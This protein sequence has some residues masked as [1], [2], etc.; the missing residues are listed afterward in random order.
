MLEHIAGP[1]I[2]E[3]EPRR[4]CPG[5]IAHRHQHCT[6]CKGQLVAGRWACFF[7]EGEVVLQIGHAAPIFT[8]GAMLRPEAVACG[9]VPRPRRSS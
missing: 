9:P 2:D 5:Y 4:S 6:R 8:G 7:L 1:V 3:I